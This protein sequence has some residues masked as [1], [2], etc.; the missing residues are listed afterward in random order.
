MGEVEEEE[1]AVSMNEKDCM[2]KKN[3]LKEKESLAETFVTM[4]GQF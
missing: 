3:R 1:A 2:K 4:Q